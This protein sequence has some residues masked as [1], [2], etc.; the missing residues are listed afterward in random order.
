ME[1][2]ELARKKSFAPSQ[3][4]ISKSNH[5]SKLV[6]QFGCCQKPRVREYSS[7]QRSKPFFAQQTLL[8][9]THR[10]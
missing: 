3:R 4:Q 9:H 10:T 1:Q 7:S 5:V 8:S 6:K 2:I